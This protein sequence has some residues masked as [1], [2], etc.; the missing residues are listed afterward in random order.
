MKKISA[1]Y[2]YRNDSLS[3]F[4][5]KYRPSFSLMKDYIK[6]DLIESITLEIEEEG[7]FNFEELS[8]G[9]DTEFRAEL[10]VLRK[11][12]LK[13][14]INLLHAIG[15]TQKSSECS[16]LIEDLKQLLIPKN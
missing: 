14:V 9:Y 16:Y 4:D 10:I 12:E 8:R 2:L 5:E 6:R 15:K 11:N 3:E 1:N 7:L 13:N